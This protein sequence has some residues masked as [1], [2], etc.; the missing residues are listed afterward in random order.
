MLKSFSVFDEIQSADVFINVPIAKHHG[1][2]RLTLGIKNLMGVMG[3]NRG[4]IH[5]GDIHQK[6]AD[7]YS[8]VKPHLTSIDA[9]R[10]LLEKGPKGG[11]TNFVREPKTIIASTDTVAADAYATTLF[12]EYDGWKDITPEKIGH[13]KYAYEMGLGEMRLDKIKVVECGKL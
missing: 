13:I 12:K 1:S 5:Q 2:T 7:Y 4:Q 8:A 10:S 6:L 3:G 11:G 9:T